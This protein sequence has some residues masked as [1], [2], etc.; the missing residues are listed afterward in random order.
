MQEW[1]SVTINEAEFQYLTGNSNSVYK[2]ST[3]LDIIPNAFI[4]RIFGTDDVTDKLREHEIIQVI[5]QCG[6]APRI[7]AY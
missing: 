7:F 1:E 6:L 5:S 4:Y 3:K 2:I